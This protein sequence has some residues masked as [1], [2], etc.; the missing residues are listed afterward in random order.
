MLYY[1]ITIQRQHTSKFQKK[2]YGKGPSLYSPANFLKSQLLY[3]AC[4]G[5]PFIGRKLIRNPMMAENVFASVDNCIC[6]YISQAFNFNES[7]VVISY[8]QIVFFHTVY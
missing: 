1:L 5:G 3:G 8:E 2:T 4:N 6:I 7:A